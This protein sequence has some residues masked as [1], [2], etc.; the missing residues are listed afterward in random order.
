MRGGV[1]ER[2]FG[3]RRP[4][5]IGA[6][7]VGTALFCAAT[8]SLYMSDRGSFVAKLWSDAQSRNISTWDVLALAFGWFDSDPDVLNRARNQPEVVMPVK[9]YVEKRVSP[10]RIETGKLKI[11]EYQTAIAG[12]EKKYGV[13]ARMLVSIW[14]I[15]SNFGKTM[16]DKNV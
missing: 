4:W 13:P 8:V 10:A 7:L 9:D 15:E 6:L 1:T 3:M 2:N 11:A 5:K 16:G 12:I 14:G